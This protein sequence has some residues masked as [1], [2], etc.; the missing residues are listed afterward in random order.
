MRSGATLYG[1]RAYAQYY[2]TVTDGRHEHWAE[3]VALPVSAPG[4]WGHA[5]D[6]P[7]RGPKRASARHSSTDILKQPRTPPRPALLGRTERSH[8]RFDCYFTLCPHTEVDQS[9]MARHG[10]SRHHGPYAAR[11]GPCSGKRVS[12]AGSGGGGGGVTWP[13]TPTPKLASLAA[14]HGA[15]GEACTGGR[16]RFLRGLT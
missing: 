13:S 11:L 6:T 10:H 3:T 15:A 2:I 4:G 5:R 1:H 7:T 12:A 8:A 14:G 9:Q 16:R